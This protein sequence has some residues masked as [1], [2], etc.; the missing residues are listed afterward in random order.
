MWEVKAAILWKIHPLSFQSSQ[1]HQNKTY[2]CWSHSHPFT[3][4]S[5][6][7]SYSKY[8]YHLPDLSLEIPCPPHSYRSLSCS[9]L[10]VLLTFLKSPW[11]LYFLSLWAG[12]LRLLLF[13][14][15]PLQ[16]SLSTEEPRSL[17]ICHPFSVLANSLLPLLSSSLILHPSFSK[18]LVPVIFKFAIFYSA[19]NLC[20]LGLKIHVKYLGFLNY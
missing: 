7:S 13:K 14:L 20:I 2:H 5:L 18:P 19:R 15:S 10:A 6:L 1:C 8:F 11:F 4:P 16:S 9:L 3:F 17:K 12:L